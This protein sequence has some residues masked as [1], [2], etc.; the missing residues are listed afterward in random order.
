MESRSVKT[1][2]QVE[3]RMINLSAELGWIS[4]NLPL[5]PRL[6]LGLRCRFS[7]T[8]PRSAGRFIPLLLQ[9][10]ESSLTSNTNCLDKDESWPPMF[11]IFHRPVITIIQAPNSTAITDRHHRSVNL[12]NIVGINS[13]KSITGQHN[14]WNIVESQS[15]KVSQVS[16]IL[17]TFLRAGQT[18]PTDRSNKEAPASRAWVGHWKLAPHQFTRW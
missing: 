8:H 10:L 14:L 5:S 9:S 7:M 17:Q 6:C 11:V 4:E 15:Q 18:N 3:S 1:F 13:G 2:P 12:A 16:E